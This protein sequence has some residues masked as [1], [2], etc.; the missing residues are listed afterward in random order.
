MGTRLASALLLG[1][2]AASCSNAQETVN[3]MPDV[4]TAPDVPAVDM[5]MVTVNCGA[6]TACGT[7]TSL[8]PCGWCG[9]TNTCMAGN[10]TGPSA[11]SC[12]VG[13]TMTATTCPVMDAGPP[14][15][16][17]VDAGTPDTGPADTGVVDTGVVDAG[18]MDAGSDPCAAQT[19][20]D[21][22][23][24]ESECGWCGATGRCSRGTSTGPTGATCASG[25][26]WTRS[27]CMST[28]TD[29]GDPCSSA[30][31]CSACTSR[32]QCGWCAATGRCSVGSSS[33]PTGSTC[34]AGSWAWISSACMNVGVDA[35]DPCGSATDCFAC[36]QRSQCGWCPGANRCMV[37]TSTGPTG[38]VMGGSCG[39]WAWYS[40][41]CGPRDGGAV[42]VPQDVPRDVPTDAPRDGG[43]NTGIISGFRDPS[44]INAT[45][46][47]R[48]CPS[49]GT[50]RIRLARVFAQPVNPQNNQGW[51]A[52][53][54]ITDLV[55]PA[56]SDR[57][58]EAL[59]DQINGIRMGTGDTADRLAG[60]AFRTVVA[61]QCGLAADWIFGRWLAPDMFGILRQPPSSTS[62]W[63]T[64]TEDDSFEAP[65]AGAMWPAERST[66]RVPCA[67]RGVN[68]YSLEIRDEEPLSLWTS[69][70]TMTFRASEITPEAIC[71]GWAFHDG[72]AGVAGVLFEVGVEGATPNCTGLR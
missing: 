56:A 26:S 11:G 5:P 13:W 4:V 1:A 66:L 18:T 53:P 68:Q 63:T 47:M 59:R 19:M 31:S 39:T 69:M 3:G 14:D 44:M 24:A 27:S 6:V 22:C 55:C 51:D 42:D 61:Q 57:I 60:E 43:Q 23:T 64:P 16:G 29:A 37:G 30:T 50:L 67:T 38:T 41:A 32:S 62:I 49:G 2:L 34:G 7:C 36:T 12:A 15:T 33:G 58:R 8:G 71:S 52:I 25:W 35:G 45:D 54:G 9:L 21:T 40:S 28:G 70:G 65:R 46:A 20:C 17:V 48:T 72:F 10:A